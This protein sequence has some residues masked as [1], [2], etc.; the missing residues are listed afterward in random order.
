MGDQDTYGL[1]IRIG[2]Y[3]QWVIT[4][5][6][7]LFVRSEVDTVRVVNDLFHAAMF[8]GFAYLTITKGPN[9]VVVEPLLMMQFCVGVIIPMPVKSHNK[10]CL[11]KF[12]NEVLGCSSLDSHLLG[13]FFRSLLCTAWT[14]YGLWWVFGGMNGMMPSP[15]ISVEGCVSSDCDGIVDLLGSPNTLRKVLY[16]TAFIFSSVGLILSTILLLKIKYQTKGGGEDEGNIDQDDVSRVSTRFDRFGA[17]C[18]RYWVVLRFAMIAFSAIY[19][20]ES[21]IKCNKIEGV[22]NIGSTGQILPLII[23]FGGLARIMVI[24]IR[25]SN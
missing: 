4:M 21:I 23:G 24:W 13:Y 10:S 15:V 16:V 1:G 11:L 18:D 3:L 7:H 5:F 14:S 17:V 9:M 22:G 8:G 12:A 25:G 20:I 19:C 6:T 2:I